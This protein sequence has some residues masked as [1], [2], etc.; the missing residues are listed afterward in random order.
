MK[1]LRSLCLAL[2][3]CFLAA[4]SHHQ[5]CGPVEFG[6]LGPQIEKAFT[7][8]RT[9]SGGSIT[10]ATLRQSLVVNGANAKKAL[11]A[12]RDSALPLEVRY[13]PGHP[14]STMTFQSHVLSPAG[15]YE[16]T[17][18][19]AWETLQDVAESKFKRDTRRGAFPPIGAIDS[20]GKIVVTDTW[21]VDGIRIEL[22]VRGGTLYGDPAMKYTA[23]LKVTDLA[24]SPSA[25]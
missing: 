11:F 17:V 3:L 18:K 19:Q 5:A 10:A 9:S 1:L 4:S 16:T 15:E 25:N 20:S 24:A 7:K 14:L 6:M 2:P 8:L 21:E 12:A 22:G 13:A 23:V